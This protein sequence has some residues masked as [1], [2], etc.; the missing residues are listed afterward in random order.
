MGTFLYNI[1]V[2]PIEMFVEFV[3]IFFERG[4]ANAGIAIAAI[5]VIVNLLALPLYN[6]AEKLQREERDVRIQLLPG[7]TRIKSTFKGDEQYMMLS[8]F[9]RQNHYHPAYA[10][11]S[12]ISLIIQV[13]FFIAAYHFLSH[14]EQLQ[15]QSFAFIPNLGIPD[16]LLSF[17]GV[18]INLLPLLMTL[19][20]VI[21]GVI[22]TKG[23]PLRDK[24]QLYGMAGLF[25]VLL[26]QSPAGLVLYWTLNNGFSLIKNIFYKFKKP[27][28]VF[29]LIAVVGT[30]A[31][32]LAMW[33]VHPTLSL[34]NRTILFGGCASI[35]L[36][37]LLIRLVNDVYDR[38]LSPFAENK[39]Q[40]DLVFV[41]ST[42]LLFLI[43]GVVI[44][45]NLISSSTNEFSFTGTVGNPLVYVANTA[46]IFFGLWVVWGSFIYALANKKMKAI[47]SFLFCCLSLS[48]LLNLFVFTGKYDLVSRLLQFENPS[49]LDANAF[50]LVVPLVAIMMLVAIGLIVLKWGKAPYL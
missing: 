35:A 3:Y 29:Y 31:L 41:F 14:L 2:Y 18:T 20:N 6:I 33:I 8:T 30:F 17:G 22:Y 37:P 15:G 12:S 4:F 34:S 13:P 5:S 45:A 43:N 27:L 48:S 7:I 24:L 46:T 26:Y 19:L 47:F 42:L 49:L 21:A 39:K 23:F 32:A 50:L 25:L 10:L 28:K 40:R 9:Y 44:P 38:F 36:L 11:R 16:G 1:L